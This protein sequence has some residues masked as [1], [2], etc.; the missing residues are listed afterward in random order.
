[1]DG[2]NDDI[3]GRFKREIYYDPYTHYGD[4]DTENV[5]ENQFDDTYRNLEDFLYRNEEENINYPP[6]DKFYH[7][8]YE[9]NINPYPGSVH[10]SYPGL[11]QNPY[12]EPIQNPYL[13]PIHNPYPERIHNPYNV[14]YE[15][16]YRPKMYDMTD[17]LPEKFDIFEN[18][19][20]NIHNVPPPKNYDS[21]ED[22][23][24]YSIYKILPTNTKHQYSKNDQELSIENHH[25]H[26]INK[27]ILYEVNKGHEN[28]RE[29][30][31]TTENLSNF[32]NE[33]NTVKITTNIDPSNDTENNNMRDKR[34]K[35]RVVGG[36]SS[37][38]AAWPWVVAIYRDGLFQCGGVL[39]NDEWVMTA[40]HCF[41]KYAHMI[42]NYIL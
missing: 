41:T 1:M 39:I 36:R 23:A 34:G 29:V 14:N 18:I 27:K 2:N 28:Y 25:E 8:W 38:P 3:F 35:G 6:F 5:Y 4:P 24:I 20:S 10:N 16:E 26:Q 11:I 40:A 37:A 33:I 32:F 42:Y 15:E 21:P 31:T 19:D 9:S 30:E 12:P 13:E 22:Q 17:A 7:E